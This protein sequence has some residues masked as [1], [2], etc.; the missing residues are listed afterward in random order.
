[1]N[2]W[3]FIGKTFLPKLTWRR[4]VSDKIIY[5]TFDDGPHPEITPWVLAELAKVEAKGTFFV[6]GQNVERYPHVI[7]DTERQGHRI[8]NHTYTHPK[9]WGMTKRA[10]LAEIQACDA[11]KPG[12]ALFRPPYG[13]INFKAKQD[14][15]LTHEVIM[16]DVLTR[17]FLTGINTTRA[18]SRIKRQ[19]HNGSIIVFHDSEKAEKNLKTILPAYLQFLKKEGYKMHAL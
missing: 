2:F 6:V 17:D 5:L 19:T 7:T 10:Y 18:L 16:W 11:S 3:Y 9:G 1:M 12:M 13:Q 8:G 15:M 14:I 4:E